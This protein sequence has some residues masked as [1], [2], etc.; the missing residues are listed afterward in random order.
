[1]T[2][3]TASSLNKV[4]GAS[5]GAVPG[6]AGLKQ[7]RGTTACTSGGAARKAARRVGVTGACR[8]GG[9]YATAVAA[10]WAWEMVGCVKKHKAAGGAVG[11]RAQKGWGGTRDVMSLSS[12]AIVEGQRSGRGV[13]G[14]RYPGR[15]W[16]PM[17][18]PPGELRSS[19]AFIF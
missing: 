18:L 4:R 12:T 10:G 14:I 13:N 9:R 11:R 3:G 1:M 17:V 19:G 8:R 15:R 7:V 5:T 2:G 6:Q 16:R